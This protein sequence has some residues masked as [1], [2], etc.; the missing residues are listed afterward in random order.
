MIWVS[1]LI[2]GICLG[3]LTKALADRSLTKRTFWGRSYCEK[4]KKHLAWY[5][6]FPVLSY[7]FLK[8]KCRYC[9]SKLSFEYPLSE[10]LMGLM[11]AGIFYKYVPL[12][13]LELGWHDQ[14]LIV[15]SVLF[16]CLILVV[17]AA[18]FITDFKTGYI[19]DRI[20]YPSIWISFVYL[21]GI[22][23][24]KVY[25]IYEALKDSPV[26]KYLL[27][28]HSNYFYTHAIDLSAPLFSGALMALVL[29]VFFY[30]LILITRGKGMG[31]GDLKLGVFLGL[32]FGFPYA[33]V[34]LMLSF[35]LGSVFGVGLIL[36]GKKKFGQTIPFGPFL[37]LAGIISIF[38]G[39]QILGWYLSLTLTY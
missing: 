32:V 5:D 29:G 28:P 35:L 24:F 17:L 21:L 18:V 38:W 20:T 37:S 23:M 31:G 6:L 10:V 16:Y 3:S 36:A 15:S 9:K 7:I 26:G 14:T 39:S 25:L 8:G 13:F 12:N 1:G 30:L 4:C 19:P 27:P 11:V 34:V 2:I 22:S 33:L